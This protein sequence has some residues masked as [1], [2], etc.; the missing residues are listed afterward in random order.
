[1]QVYATTVHAARGNERV[2]E[3]WFPLALK[4]NARSWL[5]NLPEGTV[6]SWPDLCNQF[7]GAF[8]G[9]YKCPGVVSDLH[10]LVQKPGEMLRKNI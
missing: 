9:R 4:P 2:M 6:K 3:N 7:I 1:M 8:E 10:N 5:M